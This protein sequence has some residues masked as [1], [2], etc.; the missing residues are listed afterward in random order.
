VER[1]WYVNHSVA[2]SVATNSADKFN[3]SKK[4]LE[5]M[6]S[7]TDEHGDTSISKGKV[8][9]QLNALG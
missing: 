5:S 4:S 7:E 3:V 2:P 6:S 9:K 8:F 1:F